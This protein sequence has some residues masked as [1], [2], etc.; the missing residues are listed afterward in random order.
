MFPVAPAGTG[1]PPSSP[2]LDSNDSDAGL[3]RR[4]HVRQSLPAGVMKVRRQLDA[5]QRL[6]GGAEERAHLDRVGHPSRIAE[7]DLSRSRFCQRRR[8]REHPLRRH[9]P[10]IRT[11]E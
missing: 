1:H 8:H 11:A 6:A 3:E 2:K 5:R 10:L 9:V 4:Q 7:A